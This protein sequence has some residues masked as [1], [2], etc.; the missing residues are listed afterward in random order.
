VLVSVIIPA[1]NEAEHIRAVVEAARRDYTP[2]QV[3]VVVVDGGSHDGTPERVPA[4]VKLIRAPRGRAAQMNS[5]AAASQGEILLFCHADSR[6]PAAWREAVV[7]ALSRPGVSGGSFQI[8]LSPARGVLHLLNRLSFSANWR[9]MVGDQAQFMA[10]RTFEQV[11]GFPDVPLLEDL[12]MSRALHGAGRLVRI[13]LRVVTSSRRF[14]ER[15]PLCQ[16]GLDVVCV[17]RYLYLGASPE[18]LAGLY[19]SSREEVRS[20]S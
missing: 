13:P 2:T 7:H 12:E 4:G 15:G 17:F 6:L 14:L 5:G 19:V 8:R 3:E 16:F 10:R 11:G 18:E 1:L 9:I 20:G